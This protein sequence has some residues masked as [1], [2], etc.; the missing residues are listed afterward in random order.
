MEIKRINTYADSR[1]SQ[2]VLHQHGCFLVDG[3]PYE[4]E[5]LSDSEAVIRGRDRDAYPQILEEF[6]FF[7]PH[8]TS[9][10]NEAGA[11][12]KVFP[13]VRLMTIPLERIQPSQ[14]YVD[15]EKLAAVRTFIRKPEDIV[16]QVLPWEDRFISLDG[17]TRLYCAVRMGWTYVRAVADSADDYIHRFVAEAQARGIYAPKD[18]TLVCH[19]EYEEKWNRFCDDFFADE[20]K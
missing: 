17:H 16:I 20:E 3:S 5:I 12:V 19:A 2:R 15:E 18:M 7:A 11:A 1:F 9:F 13:P 14:F 8:I 6:R 10:F 4:V